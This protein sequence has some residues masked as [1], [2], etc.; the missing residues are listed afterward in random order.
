MA[1]NLVHNV[2]S[3]LVGYPV[4]SVIGWLD[5]TVALHWIQGGGSYKQF[6]AN[7]VRKI[8]EKNF[9]EWRYVNTDRNPA[10]IGSRGCKAD[11]LLGEWTQG[12]EWLTKPELWPTPVETKPSNE[13][14]AEARMIKD[15][16][17]VAL[18]SEGPLNRILQKHQYWRAIRIV[19]WIARFTHNCKSSKVNR[20]S[21]PL[22][23][24]EMNAQVRAWILRTQQNHVN[25]DKFQEDQIQL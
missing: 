24:V 12:P 22:T 13:T 21:G 20:I 15:V 10:D 14:E 1:A 25:T 11:Q 18:E 19:S 6:V 16:L 3:T 4:T 2:K 23:T 17:T 8:K 5:S 9:I 7:R